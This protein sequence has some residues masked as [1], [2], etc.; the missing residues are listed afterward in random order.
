MK[1]YF[2]AAF[3]LLCIVSLSGCAALFSSNI[4]K[5]TIESDPPLAEVKDKDGKLL[6]TTPYSF[7][8]SKEEKY[9]FVISK[10]GFEESELNVR[11][12]VNEG[13]LFADAMFLCIPCIVD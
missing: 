7:S 5:I 4:S 2:K 11:A 10:K 13:A 12:V 3:F 9:N 8:P 1:R 6:G